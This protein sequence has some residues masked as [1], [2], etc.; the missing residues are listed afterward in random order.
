M[1]THWRNFLRALA[2]EVDSSAGAAS[3]DALLRRIGERM[4]SMMPLP[5]ASS[6]ETLEIEMNDAL[7]EVGWGAVQLDLQ[8]SDRYLVLRHR[9]LPR[10]GSAGD[11]PGLWLAA[12]L[13]GLYQG[14]MGQQPGSEPSLS[15]RIQPGASLGATGDSVELRYG[16]T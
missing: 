12:V 2:E 11:P 15:A 6:L 9:G 16:R 13:E 3:R 4:A 8:E 5:A 7:A 14:W 1:Q 10:I